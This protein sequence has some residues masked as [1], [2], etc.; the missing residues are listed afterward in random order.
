[1]VSQAAMQRVARTTRAQHEPTPASAAL[2]LLIDG[3][4][5]PGMQVSY[6]SFMLIPIPGRKQQ[7][8]RRGI[9]C[10]ATNC[11]DPKRWALDVAEG[12]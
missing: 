7:R 12:L 9:Y 10:V 11:C 8:Q 5:I 6:R 2:T 1:M 4:T 3:G